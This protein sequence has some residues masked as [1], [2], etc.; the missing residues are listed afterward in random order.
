MGLST[1]VGGEESGGRHYSGA[2]TSVSE[3]GAEE[4]EVAGELDGLVG[5]AGE[6]DAELEG[7]DGGGGV[8]AP[9]GED[10]SLAT[11]GELLVVGHPREEVHHS[12]VPLAAVRHVS[13]E[14]GAVALLSRLGPHDRPYHLLLRPRPPQRP[15]RRHH[16]PV[17]LE[18]VHRHNRLQTT[19][20]FD[21]SRHTSKLG[22][23]NV[24]Q[25][26][27]GKASLKICKVKSN[28]IKVPALIVG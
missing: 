1:L 7:G 21:F 9:R 10:A 11:V 19:S 5:G 24:L 26:Y 16:V 25:K 18:V 6:A 13:L 15:P 12:G 17:H 4:G 14:L 23:T 2:A 3:A 8:L 27:Q 20:T 22:V 28:G